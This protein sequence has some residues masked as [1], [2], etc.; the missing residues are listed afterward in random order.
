M[1]LKRALLNHY[2]PWKWPRPWV[3][4]AVLASLAA[5]AAP[6]AAYA[7][8]NEDFAQGYAFVPG[9]DFSLNTPDPDGY[10]ARNYVRVYHST[11]YTWFVEY[12][13][14]SGCFDYTSNKSNPTQVTAN[15]T[16]QAFCG[17]DAD[18]SGTEF[19]CQTT[20]P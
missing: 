18:V 10:L 3:C 15:A 13:N 9:N 2:R 6:V 1:T 14:G 12:C 8:T 4:L 7:A 11:S 5:L 19:T 16:A 20:T 17:T